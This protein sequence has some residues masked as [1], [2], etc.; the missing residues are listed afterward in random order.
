MERSAAERDRLL[1]ESERARK[2][3]LREYQWAA[4]IMGTLLLVVGF[5]AYLARLE[6]ARAEKNLRLAENAV[7]EMLLSAGREQAR[8]AAV[9]G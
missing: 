3:K 9:I 7:D 6:N 8:V 2:R 5:L 4:A 1:A